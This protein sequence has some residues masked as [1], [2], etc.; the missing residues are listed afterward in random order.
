M[1]MP[2]RESEE[3]F[4]QFFEGHQNYCCMITPSGRLVDINQSALNALGYEKDEM[5]GKSM[6]P[7][8]YAPQSQ[9]K[10]NA[11]FDL[12]KQHGRIGNEELS[13]VS[14]TGEERIVIW[15]AVSTTFSGDEEGTP[16][17]FIISI[18]DLTA[19]KRIEV[20]WRQ[21]KNFS[22]N[23]LQTANM[24]FVQLDLDGNVVKLNKAA[25][26]MTGYSY[27]E[28]SGKSWFES[29]VPRAHY[30]EVWTAFEKIARQ[31]EFPEIFENPIL[32]K[33]GEE[34]YILWKNKV[35]WEANKLIG[36][37][38]FGM[39]VTE[40]KNTE[41]ALRG[42][43]KLFRTIAEN[44]P[45]SYVC[46]IEKDLSVSYTS[47]QVVKTLELDPGSFAGLTLEEV[48]GTQ[49]EVVKHYY[50]ETFK[51]KKNTFELYLNGQYQLFRT[52]PL[53]DENGEIQRILAVVEN[54][55]KRKQAEKDLMENNR[56]FSQLASAISDVFWIGDAS[57]PFNYKVV[58]VNPAFERIWQRTAEE[59]YQDSSVWYDCIYAEDKER[60]GTAFINFLQGKGNFD[61]EFRILRPD[62]TTR[63][64]YVKGNLI[65]DENGKIILAAGISRDITESKRTEIELIQY[66]EHLEELVKERTVELKQARDVADAANQA[67]SEFL[68]N[69]S[70]EIRTPMNAILGFSEILEKQIH[71]DKH[72]AYL[73]SIQASGKSL[74]TLINDILDLS[75]VEA[76][77][78]ELVY[79]HLN[80]YFVFQEMELIFSHKISQKKLN[81]QLEINPNLPQRIILDE[82][83]LRQVLLNLI[84][85]AIKFTNAGTIKL[86]LSYQGNRDDPSKIDLIFSVEDTGIGIPEDQTKIIFAP[87]E[88]QTGQS[89]AQ[90][91]GTG[92]GLAISKR[93]VELMGGHISVTSKVGEGSVFKVILEKVSIAS[94]GEN[95]DPL[96]QKWDPDTYQFEHA[97]LLIVDDVATNRSLMKEY[98][99]AYDFTLYE[100]VNGQEALELAKHYVPDLILMDMKMPVLDGYEATKQL[101]AHQATHKIPVIALTASAMKG[102]EEAYLTLGDGYLRKPVNQAELI[103]N[104]A[105]FLKHT[106]IDKTDKI[107]ITQ[108]NIG[109]PEHSEPNAFARFRDLLTS[110]EQEIS[111][112]KVFCKALIIKDIQSF[113]LRI[114]NL[115]TQYHYP[116][117]KQWGA[118]L[119][120]QASSFEVELLPETLTL[121]P[122]FLKNVRALL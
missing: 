52:V 68:A 6:I 58:Y 31:G 115:G 21:A 108:S 110:L 114:Q 42:Q 117:L 50:L 70:H 120:S 27:A 91:G 26:M 4:H 67:K 61:D 84:G 75:K 33:S 65:R 77:K 113:S 45:N 48:V 102:T 95:A 25:E 24:I 66:R 16:P 116:S 103:R 54:I 71:D 88:Q 111:A 80:P 87:F 85:N 69:M 36:S 122:E 96:Q 81:F 101:K 5:I 97:S 73:R 2:R 46:L 10:A 30:P 29:I 89:Q 55:T 105:K 18:A 82:T 74:L 94:I 86:A 57:D 44:F 78:L 43:E 11:L 60:I 20:S 99:K 92:L 106:L 121:F 9:E 17:Y 93:L 64:V 41:M 34:R 12:W 104:L 7:T 119:H 62:G 56:R 13:L 47:G 109:F 38:S 72:R 32:T 118:S 1:V 100:A 28:V 98:L 40:L 35:L 51:G 3:Q 90:Y 8:I 76:G 19:Y 49:V 112:W 15:T 14:K 79:S 23:L 39:D 63:M 22:E 37:M 53:P 83:R 107:A 59:L